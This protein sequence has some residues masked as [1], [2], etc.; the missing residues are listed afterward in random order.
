MF[1]IPV[2][3][4]A[5]TVFHALFNAVLMFHFIKW[6]CNNIKYESMMCNFL[7]EV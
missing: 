2:S 4:A 1:G 5:L 7:R 6:Q 3:V